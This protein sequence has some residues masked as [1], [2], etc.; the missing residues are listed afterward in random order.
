VVEPDNLIVLVSEADVAD[1]FNPEARDNCSEPAIVLRDEARR[2]GFDI[3]DAEGKP[4]RHA[5]HVLHWDGAVAARVL[6]ERTT[7]RGFAGASVR[8]ATGRA[9]RWFQYAHIPWDDPRV[10]LILLEPPVVSPANYDTALLDRFHTVLTWNDELVDGQ[11][12][13]KYCIPVPYAPSQPAERVPYAAK[14]LC[15]TISANKFSS[16]PTELYSARRASIRYFEQRYPEQ[17]D[18]FGVGWDQ[19]SGHPTAAPHD[20]EPYPSYRGTVQSK[21]ETLKRYRFALCYENSD[22]PAG[23]VTEKMLDVL[24][25]DCVPVYLGAPN[26]A[27]YVDT[28]AFVDRRAFESDGALADYLEQMREEE[29]SGYRS[30]ALRYLESE[31]FARFLPEAFVDDVLGVLGIPP[32][33]AAEGAAEQ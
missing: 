30:A 31:R 21:I 1:L 26:I 33:L 13:H 23:Y 14:K 29:W 28:D 19:P 25:S 10:S 3:L 18:L 11:R 12:F 17:F 24:R 2:R 32:K 4:T 6:R 7:L 16:H 9:P 5:T 20:R 15:A 22:G 8:R 27:Q